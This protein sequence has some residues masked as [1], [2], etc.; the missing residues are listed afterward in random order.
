MIKCK[1]HTITA[2]TNKD[3]SLTHAVPINASNYPVLHSRDPEFVR[4][5]LSA[6]F[7]ATKLEPGAD[8]DGLRLA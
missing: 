3:N 1:R 2:H 7:G 4:D 5:R 8:R 6:D